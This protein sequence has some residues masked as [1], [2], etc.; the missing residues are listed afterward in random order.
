M[1]LFRQ[2]DNKYG[3]S[4][5]FDIQFYY[6]KRRFGIDLFYQD[7]KGFYLK[8]DNSI[9]SDFKLKNIGMN[10]YFVFNYKQFSMPAAFK[11]S[12]KQINDAGSFLAFVS[13]V[14]QGL[15]TGKSLVPFGMQSSF[16]NDV[17]DLREGNFYTLSIGPGYAHT[18]LFT[19]DLT[20]TFLVHIG[21]GIQYQNYQTT[22]KD[23]TDFKLPLK[24]SIKLSLLYNIEHFFTGL[25]F[26]A[27]FNNVSFVETEFNI[28]TIMIKF[29]AGLRF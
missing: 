16:P 23:K 2:D 1:N 17:N 4:D 3:K 29:F 9:Y 20:F 11:Q 15:D 25:N 28:I 19:E 14:Y 13:F 12:E 24:G 27:D 7:Y 18:F 5:Y 21:A 8:K 22:T 26:H 10:A 6:F